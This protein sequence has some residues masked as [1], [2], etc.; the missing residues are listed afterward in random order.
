MSSTSS[1]ANSLNIVHMD[2]ASGFGGRFDWNSNSDVLV[3]SPVYLW[4]SASPS[5]ALESSNFLATK[6]LDPLGVR[7]PSSDLWYSHAPGPAG[8]LASVPGVGWIFGFT[9]S[10]MKESSESWLAPVQLLV[11]RRTFELFSLPL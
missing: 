7:L 10:S 3:G 4:R 1:A 8:I 11:F 2:K 6:R 5:L 9:L